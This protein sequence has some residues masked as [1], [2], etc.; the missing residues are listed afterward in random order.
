MLPVGHK[1][2][3]RAAAINS[4]ARRRPQHRCNLP[5][6]CLPI[7][8]RYA[9]RRQLTGDPSN[10]NRQPVAGLRICSIN[11]PANQFLS[12]QYS[13]SRPI[14]C[15]LRCK[16]WGRHNRKCSRSPAFLNNQ[17]VLTTSRKPRDVASGLLLP[18]LCLKDRCLPTSFL[19]R[20]QQWLRLRPSP[21]LSRG[22]L[23]KT[24]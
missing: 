6:N 21:A 14:H 24:R 3:G 16:K 23:N 20:R 22:Q 2:Q 10:N 18:R 5:F 19:T 9:T 1:T 7:P 12:L 8:S 4:I 15:R 17:T 13:P 11:R